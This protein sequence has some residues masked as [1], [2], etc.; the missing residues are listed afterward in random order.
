MRPGLALGL[1]AVSCGGQPCW[2]V[3]CL[4]PVSSPQCQHPESHNLGNTQPG[5]EELGKWLPW[6]SDR[7]VGVSGTGGPGSGQASVLT[8]GASSS[9]P[10]GLYQASLC[11]FL[12]ET[13][14]PGL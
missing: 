12:M 9:L 5:T 4:A 6:L 1:S 7:S 2:G 11:P 10:D 14:A 13:V 8:G 3:I